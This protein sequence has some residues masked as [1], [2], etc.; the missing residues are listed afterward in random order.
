MSTTQDSGETRV[1]PYVVGDVLHIGSRHRSVRRAHLSRSGNFSVE[2]VDSTLDHVTIGMKKGTYKVPVH[3]IGRGAYG[4][5]LAA[6]N[7]ANN[8][9]VAIK[10]LERLRNADVAA[11]QE[12]RIME[13][14]RNH[15]NVTHLFECMKVGPDSSAR[16]GAEHD[17]T[18]P[19]RTR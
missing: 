13:I 7:S 8:K 1:L 3:A 16:A 5:V 4:T 15:E 14:V 12:A 6:R 2:L 10:V 11:T 9:P 19:D 17:P 18:R